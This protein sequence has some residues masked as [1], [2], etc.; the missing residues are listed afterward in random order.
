MKTNLICYGVPPWFLYTQQEQIEII[1]KFL[2]QGYG[3]PTN[4]VF[5]RRNSKVQQVDLLTLQ[6]AG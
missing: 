2:L 3:Q 1:E 6:I 4:Y 5:W